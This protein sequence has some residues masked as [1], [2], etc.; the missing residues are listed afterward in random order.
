[1]SDKRIGFGERTVFVGSLVLVLVCAAVSFADVKLPA[2][3]SDNMVIQRGMKVPIW[4]WARPGEGVSISGDWQSLG[5]HTAADKDGK[6]MVKIDPPRRAGGPFEMTISGKNTITIK[7]ILA[8]EVWVASGQSNMEWSVER[9]A[10]A[11][12]EIASA[13]YPDIRLFKVERAFADTPQENCRG[14][15]SV[16][17][18]KTVAGFSAVAYFFGRQLHRELEV[19]VGLI[20]TSWGGTPAEAWTRHEVLAA[21]A[22]FKPIIERFEQAWSNYLQKM[23]DYSQELANWLSVAKQAR[24]RGGATPEEP[25]KPRP[26][27]RSKAPSQLY[28]AMIAPLIPYGIRGAIWYQGESNVDRAYQYRKLFPAMIKNW[29]TDW[30]QG[31]FPF[32]Y[33]QIAPYRY[34]RRFAGAELREAQLMTLSVPNTGMA[35]TMDIGKVDDIHPKNKQD[36]GRRLAL[37]AL[38]KTYRRE[39]IAYSGPVYRSMRAEGNRI[40]LF[41]DYVGEGLVARGGPLTDFTIAGADRNFVEA[42]AEIDGDTIVVVS[43]KVKKPVAVRFAWSNA[44]VPNLFNRERLP[45]SSFRTDAWPGV[46]ANER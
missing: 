34:G 6:W 37:W 42:R 30:G 12:K 40:R 24:E 20:Q 32:Y 27:R 9:S 38:A 23:D 8:G 1:M 25:E 14:G 26:P 31:D 2:V 35:V 29:R 44:A 39:G 18:P 19:P 4:G 33:V 15:W 41:F 43:D 11:E 16:C 46:T 13:N 21:D 10:N 22:E 36:V 17:T 28:N 5:W 7:N 3:I 45:A